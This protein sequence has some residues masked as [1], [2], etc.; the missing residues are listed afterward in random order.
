MKTTDSLPNTTMAPPPADAEKTATKAKD[1]KEEVEAARWKKARE[2]VKRAAAQG[3]KYFFRK[4]SC[5]EGI[6]TSGI[7]YADAMW[8]IYEED[9]SN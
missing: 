9:G 2:E 4:F 8:R 3:D 6:P 1:E 7:P 5:F